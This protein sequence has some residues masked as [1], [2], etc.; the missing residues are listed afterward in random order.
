LVD[1][2]LLEVDVGDLELHGQRLTHRFVGDVAELQQRLAE[3]G[4]ILLLLMQRVIE[5][6][7][8]DRS[9]ADQQLAELRAGFCGAEGG[10]QLPLC[11]HFLP[12][13]NLPERHVLDLAA[14]P[15][16]RRG[17]LVLG[18]QLVAQQR[19]AQPE[20]ASHSRYLVG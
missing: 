10:I 12:D 4:A 17:Q 18:D 16:E 19:V 15:L 13:Q 14:L 2:H 9:D 7:A 6:A 8:G 20:L 3:P 1:L 5:L 11:H